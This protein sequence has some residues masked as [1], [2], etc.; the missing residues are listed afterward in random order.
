MIKLSRAGWNNVIIFGVMGFILLINATH[1]NVFTDKSK[2]ASDDSL[3]G[4]QAVILTLELNQQVVIERIG[5]TWRA[6]PAVISGQA[7]EQMML[8]W[9]QL[10]ALP[11]TPAKNIDPQLALPVSIA[12]AGQEETVKLHLNVQTDQL[13]IYHLQRKRW[14]IVPMQMYD[15]LIPTAIFG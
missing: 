1:D 8:S 14:Y 10:T 11:Y 2:D 15:Q 9:Q 6:T 5:K 4:S 12:F 7:L 13:L 3:F